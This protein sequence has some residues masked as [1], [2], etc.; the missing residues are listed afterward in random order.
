[1]GVQGRYRP[2]GW[3][4]ILTNV[5]RIVHK[6]MS[7]QAADDWDIALYAWMTPEERQAVAKELRRR[8]YGEAVKD[9]RE[10]HPKT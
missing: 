8:Y 6:A 7:H 4:C 9:V 5:E 2:R 10:S 1:M 3:C